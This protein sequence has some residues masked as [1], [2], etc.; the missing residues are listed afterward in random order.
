MALP[1]SL[2]PIEVWP[3]VR[4]ALAAGLTDETGLEIG[5]PDVIRLMISVHLDRM[6]AGV[7]RAIDQDTAHPTGTHL[8]EGDLL[9][10]ADFGHAP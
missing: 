2:V 7:I 4:T 9:L 8:S 5:Q 3:D 1:S 6:A 10:A